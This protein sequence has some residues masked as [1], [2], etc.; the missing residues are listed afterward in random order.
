[1][2]VCKPLVPPLSAVCLLLLPPT[3]TGRSQLNDT[4]AWH[5]APCTFNPAGPFP[6]GGSRVREHQAVLTTRNI[7]GAA[8]R[9]VEQGQLGAP[10]ESK[11]GDQKLP[12]S[13]LFF[14]VMFM[15]QDC[16]HE[17]PWLSPTLVLAAGTT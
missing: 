2:L 16:V 4:A 12:A 7:T 9:A 5:H 11:G 10:P 15:G 14:L 17:Q 8:F 3:H 1:M 6:L 13:W